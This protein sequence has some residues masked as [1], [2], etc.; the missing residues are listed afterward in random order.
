MEEEKLE[1][2][3]AKE[4]CVDREAE[5]IDQTAIELNEKENE[6]NQE[7][8]EQ[9]EAELEA[10]KH[11][12]EDHERELKRLADIATAEKAANLEKENST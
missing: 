6:M 12:Q 5:G 9:A 2:V 10:A 1:A 4:I 7:E 3:A 11:A 8:R